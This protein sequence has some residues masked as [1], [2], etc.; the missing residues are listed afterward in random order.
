MTFEIKHEM[1]VENP[2]NPE[3]TNTYILE[4]TIYLSSSFDNPFVAVIPVFKE[5]KIIEGVVDIIHK[6][7]GAVTVKGNLKE[8]GETLIEKRENKNGSISGFKR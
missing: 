2:E 3:E 8:L 5:G 4:G 6:D 7:Y 1:V